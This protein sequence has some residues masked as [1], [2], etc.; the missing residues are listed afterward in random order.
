MTDLSRRR[1]L[2]LKT[3]YRGLELSGASE[4]L[5]EEAMARLDTYD[6]DEAL[7]AALRLF[8]RNASL[9]ETVS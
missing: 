3:F 1:R 8:L 9:E 6:P 4:A 7:K 5:L 2:P